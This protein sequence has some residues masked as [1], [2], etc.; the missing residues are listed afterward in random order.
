MLDHILK[1]LEL[2]G[3]LISLFAVG[4]IVVGFAKSIGQYALRYSELGQEEN[5][6]RFKSGLGQSLALSLEI[7]IIADVIETIT[8]EP[9]FRSLGVLALLVM[10]RTVMSWMLLLEIE[11]RWP[12]QA[13]A[14]EPENG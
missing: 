12:W 10:V 5:F 3:G 13:R 14:E 9:T 8:V 1:I 6:G 2:G 11:G 4:V 7:L